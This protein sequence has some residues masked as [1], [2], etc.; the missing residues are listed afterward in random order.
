MLASRLLF[1]RRRYSALERVTCLGLARVHLV[2]TAM[3]HL[4]ALPSVSRVWGAVA[5]GMGVG[6]RDTAVRADVR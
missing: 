2:V 6:R 1:I 3:L 4:P 5:E